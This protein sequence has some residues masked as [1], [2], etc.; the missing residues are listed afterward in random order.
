MKVGAL[1]V[2]LICTFSVCH[3]Q[4]Q[5]KHPGGSAQG[6]LNVTATVVPSVWL[7]M[8][9]DGKQDVIVANAPDPKESFYRAA[10]AKKQKPLRGQRA[11]NMMPVVRN[12]TAPAVQT[13]A[14][15]TE[16]FVRSKPVG[17]QF[18]LRGEPSIRFSLPTASNK[19]EVS[20]QT[21]SMDVTEG[22]KTQRRPVTVTTIVA[23]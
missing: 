7:V 13:S 22:G 20:R 23:R 17:D 5:S 19:F 8:E 16:S 12:K 2:L 14:A 21:V 1:F 4:S 9:P 11:Q 15:S 18:L 6:S 10:P 3:S